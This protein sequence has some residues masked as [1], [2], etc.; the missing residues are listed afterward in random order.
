MKI[1]FEFNV[2]KMATEYGWF[3]VLPSIEVKHKYW[4]LWQVLFSWGYWAFMLDICR[5]DWRGN[6]EKEED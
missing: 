2:C 5:K 4:Y 3:Y 6:N 1:P